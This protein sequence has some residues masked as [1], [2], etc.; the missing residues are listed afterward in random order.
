M[1]RYD[2]QSDVLIDLGP[3]STETKGNPISGGD[4]TAQLAFG[5]GLVED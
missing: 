5:M 4:D 2:E 3:A 1:Q